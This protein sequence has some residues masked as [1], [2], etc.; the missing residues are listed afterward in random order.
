MEVGLVDTSPISKPDLPKK[1]MDLSKIQSFALLE[2]KMKY[3]ANRQQII[4]ENFANVDTPKYKRKDLKEPDF[5]EVFQKKLSVLEPS[6]THHNHMS[7]LDDGTLGGRKIIATEEKVQLD[8][9]ALEMMKNSTSYTE[10]SS[11]YKKFL[12]LIKIAVEGSGSR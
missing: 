12:S 2:E 6:A 11:T 8:M 3:N 9:E 1:P 5:N 7:G 10:A 4:S